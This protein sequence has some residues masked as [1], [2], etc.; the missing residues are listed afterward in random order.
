MNKEQLIE[1]IQI[2]HRQLMRYLFFVER[3]NEGRFVPA[4]RPKFSYDEMAQPGVIGAW[5]AVSGRLSAGAPRAGA[6]EKQ[7]TGQ[8]SQLLQR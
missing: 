3:N 5:S 7:R 2:K 1:T 8:H 6:I 4:N